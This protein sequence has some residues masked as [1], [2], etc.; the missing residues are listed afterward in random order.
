MQEEG[1]KLS[2]KQGFYR[3]PAKGNP[4]AFDLERTSFNEVRILSACSFQNKILIQ[5]ISLPL[6]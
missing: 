6:T 4:D 3:I 1:S 2:L 5:E